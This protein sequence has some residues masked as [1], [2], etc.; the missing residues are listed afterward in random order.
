VAKE[1]R[2]KWLDRIAKVDRTV[3]RIADAP[4]NLVGRGR[5]ISDSAK[6]DL[7]EKGVDG[8]ATV[9]K[10]PSKHRV[11]KV[12]DNVGRFTVR[13]AIADEELYEANVWQEF[14]ADEWEQLQPGM[15]VACKVDPENQER[16]WLTP[17]GF[18]EPPKFVGG[19]SVN[20][21]G[22]DRITDSGQLIATGR[23]ATA[24]V[25][26]SSPLGKKAP[27]TDDEFFL[28]DLELIADDEPQPWK[29]NFGQRVP[30][31]AEEMVAPGSELQVAF[32]G[33]LVA[34]DWPATSG[35]HF[36]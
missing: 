26:S 30:K 18:R 19:P 24:T 29:A 15:E 13:V 31:G 5:P 27:G 7:W 23:R 6:R 4:A 34:V 12:R 36:T 16:I 28:L 22:S 20:L 32:Q 25:L 8:I 17:T 2:R 33:D 21:G 10:A 14:M 11:S 1:G 3:E 9:L 35:G